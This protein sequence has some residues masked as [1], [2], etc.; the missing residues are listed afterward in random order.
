MKDIEELKNIG[1]KTARYLREV[2]I[3]TDADLRKAGIEET[4]RRLFFRYRDEMNF[5]SVYLY[6]LEGGL[7]DCHWN[8]ISDRRKKELKS[9][10]QKI[11]IK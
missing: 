6:A 1:P 9:I 11:Y 10:F 7:C 2:G 3:A 4:F 8:A 5:T